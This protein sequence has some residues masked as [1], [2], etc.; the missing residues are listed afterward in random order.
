MDDK[1]IKQWAD[2]N[3]AMINSLNK[4]FFFGLS[5]TTIYTANKLALTKLTG[6]F[7]DWSQWVL[8][9]GSVVIA[10]FVFRMI[11]SSKESIKLTF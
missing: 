2:K 10:F 1:V 4:L 6:E 8:S 11:F 7:P 5:V 3:V 9:T